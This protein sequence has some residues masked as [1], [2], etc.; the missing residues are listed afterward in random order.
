MS[1]DLFDYMFDVNRDGKLS[2]IE[3]VAKHA[4]I[5]ELLESEEKKEKEHQP[6]TYKYETADGAN[7]NDD[8]SIIAEKRR[9]LEAVG[10]DEEWV[11]SM[12][13][14]ERALELSV[15]GLDINDYSYLWE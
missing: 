5:N 15:V 2:F 8:D 1:K 3:K 13:P 4:F 14:E 12:N 11:K 10:L 9:R 7:Q 6:Q